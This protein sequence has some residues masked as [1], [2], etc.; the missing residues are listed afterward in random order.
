MRMEDSDFNTPTCL[1]D[2]TEK[3]VCNLLDHIGGFP[4]E[5]SKDF[6]VVSVTIDSNLN[7]GE[8]ALSDTCHVSVKGTNEKQDNH[9]AKA[10]YLNGNNIE[11]KESL[12]YE[13]N[14]DGSDR[15]GM[16]TILTSNHENHL[17]ANENGVVAKDIVYNL[18]IKLVPEDLKDLIDKHGLFGRE[19]TIYR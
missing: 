3:W 19:I 11:L 15:I 18:F 4:S 6:S 9:S 14:N 7:S 1:D 8:G 2:V 12:S 17:M 16:D 10:I 13:S 5:T